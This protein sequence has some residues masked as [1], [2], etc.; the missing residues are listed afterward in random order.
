MPE[1]DAG[2]V[3]SPPPVRRGRGGRR[4]R[5]GTTALVVL[6]LAAAVATY[7]FDLGARWFGFDYPSPVRDPAK[8][9]PPAGLTL[10]AARQAAAVAPAAPDVAVDR[11]AV[12]RALARFVRAKKLGS[13]VA[14]DV[15]RLSDGAPV[16]RHGAR[17]VTPAST[18]KVLTAVAA[19]EALGPAHR[20][21]TQVVATPQSPR[22]FLVGGGDP[23]LSGAPTDPD[24]TYPARADLDTLARAT[25][26]ALKA[27]GRSRVRLGYDTSLFAGP[28]VN[29]RWPASYVSDNVV[30]PI[31]PLWVDEGR[32]RPGLSLRSA[33]PA[34]SA[35]QQFAARLRSRGVAVVGRPA[36]GVAPQQE[37][38]GQPIADVHGA[39]LAQ[40][41]QHVLEVSDNEGAEVL[42]RQVALAEGQPASF[43]GGALAVK[44]V[45]GRVGVDT[46]GDRIYDGSGLSRQDRLRPDTL[47]A[48]MRVASS[49]DHP[50][51]RTAVAALPV[52][53][54]SG[55]LAYRF[56]TGDR[57][58]LGT[59]RAKTGTFTGVHGLTGT[60]TSV[61]G[62]VMSFVAIADRVRPPNTSD[63]RALLDEVAAALA[64]CVC[65]A[66]P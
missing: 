21:T 48:V 15:A 47:L 37:A 29:P 65:A 43:T 50:D 45:L 2:H 38:G 18:L 34:A 30:S 55:S 46:T 58:A 41:V 17:I 7:Q 31:S 52:A 56:E 33:D 10:P 20:F 54:F 44:E 11:T 25:A 12:S 60:V 5:R 57:A 59:V 3:A 1:G 40:V 62:A 61:D 22:I 32:E 23:L 49:E 53:G 51:L 26:K 16:Y 9:L 24:G 42:A 19:L 36:P 6:V 28:A 63:A 64:G 66:T 35:A 39:P 14:L 8:V 4:L 13:H 27:V